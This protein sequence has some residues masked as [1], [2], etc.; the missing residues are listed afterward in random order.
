VT[1]ASLRSA[2][3]AFALVLLGTL[4]CGLMPNYLP[5]PA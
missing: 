2:C 5:V 3:K 1:P 4:R